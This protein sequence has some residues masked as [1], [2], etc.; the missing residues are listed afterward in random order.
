MSITVYIITVP[1]PLPDVSVTNYKVTSPHSQ[2][3]L[4]LK[5]R[6]R[7]FRRSDPLILMCWVLLSSAVKS[8]TFYLGQ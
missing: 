2:P 8:T 7:P 5:Q 4:E 1:L 6:Q 3:N